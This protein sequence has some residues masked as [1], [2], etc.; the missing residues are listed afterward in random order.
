M[1][2]WQ[3]PC[4]KPEMLQGQYQSMYPDMYYKIQPHVLM[5]CDEMDAHGVMMPTNQMMGC[6]VKHIYDN[7]CKMYPDMANYGQASPATA[8][9]YSAMEFIWGTPA[10]DIIGILLLAEFFRRRRRYY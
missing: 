8:K 5:A 6:M 10:M 7:V 2:Y 9:G 1:P 3:H 4:L